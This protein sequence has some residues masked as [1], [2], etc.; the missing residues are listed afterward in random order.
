MQYVYIGNVIGEN[1]ENTF[2]PRCKKELIQ[3]HGYVIEKNVIINGKCP[4]CGY[5]IYGVWS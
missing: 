3:R 2:C 1:W 4:Y 5:K